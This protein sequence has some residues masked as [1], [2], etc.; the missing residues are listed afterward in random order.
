MITRE[1]RKE[2]VRNTAEH[3]C[4]TKRGR[5]TGDDYDDDAKEGEERAQKAGRKTTDKIASSN[6][7]GGSKNRKNLIYAFAFLPG[8]GRSL[9]QVAHG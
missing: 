1:G 6:A 9:L 8:E 5:Q 7:D 3:E 4:G 2:G